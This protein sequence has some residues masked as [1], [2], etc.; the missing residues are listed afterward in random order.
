MFSRVSTRSAA[1]LCAVALLAGCSAPTQLSVGNA[2]AGLFFKVPSTWT[3]ID[4]RLVDAA[5]KGWTTSESGAAILKSTLWFEIWTE[6]D[7]IDV[8]AALSNSVVDS[9]VVIATVRNL[10]EIEKKNLG[11]DIK[12]ALQDLVVPVSTAVEGDGLEIASN[13]R[14]AFSGYEGIQQLLSW[15][16][17]GSTQTFR[18]LALIDADQNH[19]YL[20]VARCSDICFSENQNAIDSIIKSI[21]L[22]EPI[23]A[24]L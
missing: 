7:S 6:S 13:D 10:L 12:I 21:A 5:Q 1:A 15:D 14:F 20:V 11:N 8:N 3:K 22:K 19:L 9:P 23:N 4:K 2:A 24:N 18:V 17:D 16:V